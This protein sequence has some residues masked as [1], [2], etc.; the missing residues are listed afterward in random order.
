MVRLSRGTGGRSCPWTVAAMAMAAATRSDLDAHDTIGVYTCIEMTLS[1][2]RIDVSTALF[3]LPCA[4]GSLRRATRVVTRIY[5]E[6]LRPSG[7]EI[8]QFGL[9]ASL[10]R[11][12]EGTQ[13]Q[14]SVG[15]AMDSTT[16]TRTLGLLQRRGWI[17]RKPGKDKR[18]RI[19]RLTKH[20]RARLEKA[21]PLWRKAQEDL[22]ALIGKDAFE[23]LT[24]V[25]HD[26]VAS[27]HPDKSA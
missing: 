19:L 6:A 8:M 20:G 15:F 1:T 10:D 4:C 23:T 24:R 7:L 5:D 27:L 14:L 9:M 16:L 17:E 22:Y 13:R 26:I 3:G 12:G 25:S 18:Q 21:R 2:A 11:L